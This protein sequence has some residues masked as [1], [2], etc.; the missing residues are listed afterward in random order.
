MMASNGETVLIVGASFAGLSSAY[1]MSEFGYDVTVVEIAPAVRRGGTA[2]NIQGATID[3]V[4]QMGL[5]EKIRSN[6]LSLRRWDFMD[7]DDR[8]VRSLE[9]QAEGQPPSEDDY[10][11]ERDVL[12]DILLDAVKDRCRLVFNETVTAMRETSRVDVTF[13]SGL[14]RSFDLMLGCDGTHSVVRKLWFGEEATFLHYLQ[15]YFSITIVDK[16]LIERDTAQMYNEPGKAVMLNAYKNKTDI[17]FCFASDEQIPYDYRDTA[18]QRGMI[19]TQFDAVGWRTAELLREIKNSDSFY[20]DKLCQVRMP[21]WSKGRIALVGDAAY[22]PSPAA[23][24]GGSVAIDGAAALGEAMRAAKSNHALA[25]R[26][27]AESFRPFIEEVQ[28]DAVRV[29]LE[30][31]VPRTEEAIRE[32]NSRTDGGF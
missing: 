2:V 14:R 8:T 29:G 10:E 20:F 11:V 30:T 21:S 25:F 22:C 6:R 28:A 7:R 23:G 5:F 4:K 18:E 19:A 32:R 15:Q 31:L 24:R 26:N 1:W 17:I 3:V 13:R 9:L 12:V 27:Y 16:L